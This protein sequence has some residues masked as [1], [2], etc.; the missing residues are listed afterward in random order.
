MLGAAA[1]ALGMATGCLQIAEP[2]PSAMSDGPA[3][4]ADRSIVDEEGILGADGTEP[5]ALLKPADGASVDDE[6]PGDAGRL[7]TRDCRGSATP[8]SLR[9]EFNCERGAG[10]RAEERCEGLA[11]SCGTL[12]QSACTWQQ[13]CHWNQRDRR[14]QGIATPCTFLSAWQCSW[15]DG[16]RATSDCTGLAV[17]CDRL[18]DFTCAQQPGCWR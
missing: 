14:C 6:P 8:C 5:E 11:W 9:S 1:A 13:G 17:S 18:S 15:Q 3:G 10:C 7:L 12:S 16:C 2:E 4:T